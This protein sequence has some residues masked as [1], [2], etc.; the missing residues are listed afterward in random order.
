MPDNADSAAL[1]DALETEALK[2]AA[3]AGYSICNDTDAPVWAALGLRDGKIWHSRGWWKVAP[4]ACA[5]AI[6]EAARHD[7]IYLLVERKDGH[8]SSPA[9]RNSAS[10]TS[11][12]MSEW[13]GT[14]RS[15][16]SRP[17]A[18]PSPTPG[19]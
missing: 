5:S 18:S 12:S 10:P 2:V 15:A 17:P 11:L 9:R 14:A 16:G 4:G 1:F 8:V 13:R 7:K 19:R 6:A 3:P